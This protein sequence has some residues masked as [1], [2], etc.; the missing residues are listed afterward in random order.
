MATRAQLRARAVQAGTHEGLA[1]APA[2][3]GGIDGQHPE[4]ASPGPASS[5]Y[6]EPGQHERHRAEHLAGVWIDGDEHSVPGARAG[7]VGEH[8]S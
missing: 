1:D 2:L 6:G 5:A 7:H 3:G 4:L 8:P